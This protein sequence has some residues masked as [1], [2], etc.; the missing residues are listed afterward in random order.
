MKQEKEYL[1]FERE[2]YGP[3]Y[4]PVPLSRNLFSLRIGILGHFIIG[5]LILSEIFFMALF[6]MSFFP[7]TKDFVNN[8]L[9]F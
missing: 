5:T 8:L 7:K 9:T 2:D 1:E 4:R 6:V 3:A